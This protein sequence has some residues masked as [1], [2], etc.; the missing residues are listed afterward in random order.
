[1][2]V[3]QR[4]SVT[5]RSR[6]LR[7][8]T[9]GGNTSSPS[10]QSTTTAPTAGA[11]SDL[12]Q[13][14]KDA[15]IFAYPLV[16]YYRTMYR[17]AIEGDRAFGKWLHLG[18]SNPQDKDINTPNDTPYSVLHRQQHPRPQTESRRVLNPLLLS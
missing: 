5:A 17:Q 12:R 1:M 8:W 16:M 14:A 15:Y 4:R 9:A 18:T 2:R 11:A 10:P 3:W 13:K 7:F 6:S